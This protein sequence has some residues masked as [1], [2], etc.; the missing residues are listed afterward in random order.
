MWIM[1]NLG[2]FSIVQ[3]PRD[4]GAGTLTV[5]ARVKAD[6][7]N[8]RTQYIPFLG[9]IAEHSGSDYRFRATAPQKDVAAALGQMALNLNYSNFKDE[10]AKRQGKARALAYGKVWNALYELQD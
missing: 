5:R 6:L 9:A 7:E 3:K 10:V 4:K 1:S 8:L 2:F